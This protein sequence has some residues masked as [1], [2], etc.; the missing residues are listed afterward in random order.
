MDLGPQ[1]YPQNHI[2]STATPRSASEWST[3]WGTPFGGRICGHLQVPPPPNR[4]VPMTQRDQTPWLMKG[5]PP[6]SL[7]LT[8]AAEW[9]WHQL[10]SLETDWFQPIRMHINQQR[11]CL[12]KHPTLR[13]WSVQYCRELCYGI[14]F[15]C[16]CVDTLTIFSNGS[17][18][19]L[20]L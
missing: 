1:L 17:F 12:P 8:K 13:A 4:C 2:P 19:M 9:W 3:G 10:Y 7:I 15:L 11:L 14:I 18:Y 16:V 20:E 6:T 5:T